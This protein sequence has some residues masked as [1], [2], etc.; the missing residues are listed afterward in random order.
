[1]NRRW[2]IVYCCSVL[3]G[4]SLIVRFFVL[5]PMIGWVVRTLCVGMVAGYALLLHR[6]GMPN[7]T[8]RRMERIYYGVAGVSG[9]LGWLCYGVMW[10]MER[11]GLD[12]WGL[13]LGRGFLQ[14]VPCIFLFGSDAFGGLFWRALMS[15]LVYGTVASLCD[16]RPSGRP[17]KFRSRRRHEEVYEALS[18]AAQDHSE[19]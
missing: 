13:E 4:Y 8:I 1:M 11:A 6:S 2:L 12:P 15:M 9:A 14:E 18:S 19:S 16:I 10:C 7:E 17:R 3:I 5:D